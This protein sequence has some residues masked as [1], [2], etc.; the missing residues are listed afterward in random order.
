M[1]ALTVQRMPRSWLLMS[2]LAALCS[3]TLAA[4]TPTPPTADAAW[5]RTPSGLA[6]QTVVTGR[7]RLVTK[8]DTVTIHEALSLPDGRTVFDSR[9][10]PNKPVT[11]TL[12]SGQVIPGVEEGVASMRVGE[13]RRLRVPPALDGRA[14]DPSFIPPDVMRLYDIEL[15]EARP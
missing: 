11:F 9:V 14:F 10:A 3:T 5:T 4:Q 15:L 8:G 2:F 6:F 13:R 1:P 7:G 12:G